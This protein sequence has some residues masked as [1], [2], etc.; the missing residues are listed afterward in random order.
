MV[1]TWKRMIW[2]KAFYKDWG[3]PRLFF[4]IFEKNSSPK[5]LNWSKNSRIFQAKTQRTGNDSS[6]VNFKTHSIFCIFAINEPK[7]GKFARS[8]PKKCYVWYFLSKF[9]AKHSHFSKYLTPNLQ[10][11]SALE[12]T[13][14][15]WGKNSS[16]LAPKLNEPVVT[17]Y[18]RYHKSVEKKAWANYC[19]WHLLCILTHTE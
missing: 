17:N 19:S 2:V 14:G 1:Y 7:P 3:Y 6:Q 5:K 16:F 4:N 8:A 10:N 11:S 12:K 15:L 18:T 9:P 13:Q